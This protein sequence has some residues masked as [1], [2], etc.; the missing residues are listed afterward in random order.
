MNRN[1][2]THKVLDLVVNGP[3]KAHIKGLRAT[4]VFNYFQQFRELYEEE[5]DKPLEER[6][7]PKWSCPKPTLQQCI[8]DLMDLFQNGAFI[9]DKFK[10][11]IKKSFIST[12]CAPDM[13]GN[14]HKYFAN[15]NK[16][17]LVN[18]PTGTME[19]AEFPINDEFYADLINIV[20]GDDESDE[21]ERD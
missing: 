8:L 14:Y 12:G 5:K 10:D 21:E 7:M 3:L 19:K 1:Y 17:S 2:H 13:N 20:D 9:Q 6:K 11:S 16:G 4:R 15:T 18:V